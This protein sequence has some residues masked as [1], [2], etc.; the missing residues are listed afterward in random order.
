MAAGISPTAQPWYCLVPP[1][2]TLLLPDALPG[3]LADSCSSPGSWLTPT[4][5]STCPHSCPFWPVSAASKCVSPCLPDNCTMFTHPHPGN[6]P[7]C[8]S[9]TLTTHT[10]F[11]SKSHWLYLQKIPRKKHLPPPWSEHLDFSPELLQWPPGRALCIESSLSWSQQPEK[12]LFF[13]L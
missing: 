2:G 1:L 10:S 4:V 5:P 6:L 11:V 3:A 7:R 13:K 12:F 9:H 8:L